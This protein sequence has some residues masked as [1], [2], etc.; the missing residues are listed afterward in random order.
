MGNNKLKVVLDQKNRQKHIDSLLAQDG[1]SHVQ[2][3]P[4]AAYCPISLTQAPNEIKPYLL[5]RQQILMEDVLAKVG[6]TAYDPSSAPY[7]PDKNLTSLPQEVYLV[8]S[9]KIVGARFFVGHNITAST[10]YGVEVEKAVKFNRIAVVLLDKHI[11]ISRMQPHRVIYLHYDNFEQQA[12]EFIPVFQLLKEY[13]PGVGFDGSESVLIGFHKKSGEVVN[14][15][16]LVYQRFPEFKYHYDGTQ[17]T[18]A[19]RATNPEI[20]YELDNAKHTPKE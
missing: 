16:K 8:D 5:R 19:L 20:F 1:L 18:V 9:S 11:R 2:E 15:E 10:G 6:I 12:V 17:P 14:L 3:N 7:S 13:D 4:S